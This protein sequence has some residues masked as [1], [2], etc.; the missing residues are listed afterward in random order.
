M[1]IKELYNRFRMQV[2]YLG[3]KKPVN[4]MHPLV[5]VVVT[6]YQHKEFIR[7]C[8]DAILM[9]DV[10]F[11]YEIVIGD[12]GS[13]DGTAEICKEYAFEHQ[14]KIRLYVRDRNVSH[15]IIDGKDTRYNGIWNRMS[16][17]GKYIALCEGD[18][19]WTDPLKL[20][21]QVDVLEGNPEIAMC[22]TNA[23]QLSENGLCDEQGRYSESGIASTEDVMRIGGGFARTATFMFRKSLIDN[24]PEC[25]LTCH[26]G[27]FPL[28]TFALINGGIYYLIDRTAVYRYFTTGNSWTARV[29]RA[30]VENLMK[31]WRSEFDMLSGLDE[32]SGGKY[33][34][35]FAWRAARLLYENMSRHRNKRKMIIDNFEDV[36]ACFDFKMKLKERYH[37]LLYRIRNVCHFG[38]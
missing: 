13:T 19:Y 36:Y 7:Q 34:E 28:Q 30:S 22:V 4:S 16:A 14:D 10:N 25:C 29:K 26:V 33:H 27:D 12:D 35:L 8:I 24:Y 11:D 20:Q 1:F 3:D 17:R 21:K 31:G 37:Y 2:E 23:C 38:R 5:S 32:Y 15:I 18:D 9:Q 6:T